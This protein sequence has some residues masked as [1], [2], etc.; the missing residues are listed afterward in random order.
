MMGGVGFEFGA[1]TMGM[2]WK[3]G[4]EVVIYI[5]GGEEG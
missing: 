2:E 3:S 5:Y 4:R 1:F